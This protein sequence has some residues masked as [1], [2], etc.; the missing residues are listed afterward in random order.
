MR[1]RIENE[2]QTVQRKEKEKNKN[3]KQRR[4]MERSIWRQKKS[5]AKTKPYSRSVGVKLL[6]AVTI[7]CENRSDVSTR[8]T[9]A[10]SASCSM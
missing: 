9:L 6:R 2:M 5:G 8:C 7:S 1:V 3:L 10:G 4:A